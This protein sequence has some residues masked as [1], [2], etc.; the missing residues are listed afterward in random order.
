MML[1]LNRQWH[2]VL[3][4]YGGL[5]CFPS[6]SRFDRSLAWAELCKQDRTVSLLN[7]QLISK[8]GSVTGVPASTTLLQFPV[9]INKPWCATQNP[10]PWGQPVNDGRP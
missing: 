2:K 10:V 9:L 6:N 5:I 7:A 4:L 3:E 8:Q 1:G